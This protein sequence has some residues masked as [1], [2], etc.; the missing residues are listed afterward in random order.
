LLDKQN[1]FR[2]SRSKSFDF[3]PNMSQKHAHNTELLTKK[4][5]LL[6]A[7]F[8]GNGGGMGYDAYLYSPG[9]L[10]YYQDDTT[11]AKQPVW[12]QGKIACLW[13]L[14]Q[15]YYPVRQVTQCDWVVQ[16][17]EGNVS[18]SG[19]GFEKFYGCTLVP[20]SCVVSN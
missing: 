18:R 11:D 15:T 7:N 16:L 5:N 6:K 17:T 9:E 2:V 20:A 12:K 19:F 4:G 13:N 14:S 8:S 3:T 10:V 1:L